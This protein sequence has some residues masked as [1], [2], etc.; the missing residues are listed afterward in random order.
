MEC[1]T[2]E[3]FLRWMI[4]L[5]VATSWVDCYGSERHQPPVAKHGNVQ[6]H[7]TR[8]AARIAARI[9]ELDDEDEANPWELSGL[10]EGDILLDPY[11][12]RNGLRNETMRWTDGIVPYYIKDDEFSDEEQLVILNAIREY[13]QK[14]CIKFRPYNK[15]DTNWVVFRSNASGCWSSVGM[16]PDGQTVNLQSSGCVRHGVVVHEV[17]HA[18]GFFHQQSAS[19]RD[20]YV[21]ILWD[22]I[23]PGHEHNFNKY[24]ESEVSSFGIEYDYGS[25]MHYSAKAFSRNSEPTMEALQPNVTLGQRKGLSEKDISKLELMYQ[26]QCEQRKESETAEPPGFIDQFNSLLGILKKP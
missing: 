6:P 10:F 11:H 4:V 19:N 18:L 5:A 20:D 16:Q 1:R 25:V 8:E 13:H 3:G 22:N 15:K 12:S 26:S 14:T 21:R 9:D 23:E 24:N 2:M 7:D 17:L